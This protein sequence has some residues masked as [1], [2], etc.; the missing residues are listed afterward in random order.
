MNSPSRLRH[1]PSHRAAIAR[2][3]SKQVFDYHV[4]VTMC[5]SARELGELFSKVADPTRVLEFTTQQDRVNMGWVARLRI[6]GVP[7]WQDKRIKV[8]K[9]TRVHGIAATRDP[10][11]RLFRSGAPT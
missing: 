8:L 2:L 6:S 9:A 1:S 10:T 7:N 5:D 11:T 4:S 3:R